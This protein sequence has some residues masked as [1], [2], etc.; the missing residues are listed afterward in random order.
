MKIGLRGFILGIVFKRTRLEKMTYGKQMQSGKAFEYALIN[1]LFSKLSAQTNVRII[2]NNQYHIAKECFNLEESKDQDAYKLHRSFAINL[3]LDLEPRLSNDINESDF[4]ELEIQDDT[5]GE[6]GDVRDILI[7]RAIQKWEI[8]I[9][10]KNNNDAVKHSRLSMKLNFGEKWIGIGNSQSYFDEIYPVFKE[11]E[12]IKRNS[13]KKKKWVEISDY[14]SKYYTPV[15]Q[16]FISE[17]TR[18]NNKNPGVIAPKLVE[19]LIGKKD[20]YKII[21]RSRN[22]EIQAFNL[23]GSLNKSFDGTNPIYKTPILQ[24]PKTIEKIEFKDNSINTVVVKFNDEW[25]ISFRIHNASSKVEPSLKFDVRLL[26]YPKNLFKN[27]V[28]VV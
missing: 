7:V 1:K 11:L 19:Y 26:D 20:F 13:D 5:T 28:Q 27:I 17:L 25:K 21:K 18:L 12:E 22:V 14:Q 23:N 3:L 6:I 8:G 24:L 9:S 2:E 10:A 4:L 16:A 15:L